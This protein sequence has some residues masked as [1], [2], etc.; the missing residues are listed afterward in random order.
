MPLLA[1]EVAAKVLLGYITGALVSGP[2]VYHLFSNN[3]T[4]AESDTLSNYVEVNVP[5]YS[6]ITIPVAAWV[7]ATSPQGGATATANAIQW[8]LYGTGQVY[9]YYV[10]DLTGQFLLWA[11]YL[12]GAPILI[13]PTGSVLQIQPF[14]A[15][16]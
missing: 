2:L 9:G 1:P 5:G 10:T 11:E 8:I 15:L 3:Q 6:P 12:L 4:P 16:Q 7:L 13:L 14:L